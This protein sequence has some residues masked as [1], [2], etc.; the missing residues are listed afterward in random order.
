[1]ALEQDAGWESSRRVQADSKRWMD[2]GWT[3]YGWQSFGTIAFTPLT[4]SIV[5]ESL[6]LPQNKTGKLNT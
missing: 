1:M 4:E 6:A 2:Y 3:V 5:R